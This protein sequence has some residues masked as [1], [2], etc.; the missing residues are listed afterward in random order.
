VR[1]LSVMLDSALWGVAS[2]GV[3]LTRVLLYLLA[4]ALV[5]AMLDGFGGDRTLAGVAVLLWALLPTHAVSVAWLSERKGLLAIVFA[6]SG[7]S[8]RARRR[9]RSR[10][11]LRAAARWRRD[12]ERHHRE[13]RL[14][15]AALPEPRERLLARSQTDDR[16]PARTRDHRFACVGAGNVNPI[17]MFRHDPSKTILVRGPLVR[18]R[19]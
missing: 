1:D 18:P 12:P 15:S 16:R 4:F 14:D 19:S 13:R 3:L 5:F 11:P 6:A 10:R 8:M 2:A 9:R 17:R 7:G